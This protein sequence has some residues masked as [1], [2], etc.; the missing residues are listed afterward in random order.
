[1]AQPKRT[2]PTTGENL[3]APK[4]LSDDMFYGLQLSDEQ[5]AFRDAIWDPDKE[6]VFCNAKAGTG[7]TTV[8]VGT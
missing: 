2:K 6:I 3:V 7:K 5:K 4:K 1:L 8:A